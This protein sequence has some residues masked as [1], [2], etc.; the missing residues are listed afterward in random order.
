[1]VNGVWPGASSIHR[2]IIPRAHDDIIYIA[3]TC[4][5]L[6]GSLVPRHSVAFCTRKLGGA[7]ERGYFL[8]V[9]S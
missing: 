1:M 4:H 3:I 6:L 8:G 2:G 7:W 9:L 5:V